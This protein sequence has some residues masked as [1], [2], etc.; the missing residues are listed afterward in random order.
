MDQKRP[1]RNLSDKQ[2]K[3]SKRDKLVLS[4]LGGI[5]VFIL[6]VLGLSLLISAAAESERKREATAKV[7][8]APAKKTIEQPK[9]KVE[10]KQP[11]R[12]DK[13]LN[14]PMT[15]IANEFSQ[16]YD[17]NNSR[18]IKA[19]KDGYALK[20]EDGGREDPNNP[21]KLIPTNT[22]TYTS[23]ELSEMGKCKQGD[24]YKRFDEAMKLSGLDPVTK[25]K[26][27]ETAGVGYGA[28]HNYLNKEALEI[29]LQCM[30]DGDNYELLIKVL[31]EFR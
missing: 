25:G 16:S 14:M 26:K 5:A 15:D 2:R 30:Y 31:P 29:A 22:A 7:D 28:Y 1:F 20:F 11:P 21:L 12:F 13:Y 9:Q 4:I 6:L 27:H 24:V 19:Q 8:E 17:V 3:L 23:V 10:K 18:Q